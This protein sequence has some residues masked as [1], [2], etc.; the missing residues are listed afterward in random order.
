MQLELH[1]Q[2]RSC[3]AMA[4]VALAGSELDSE[5]GRNGQTPKWAEMGGPLTQMLHCTQLLHPGNSD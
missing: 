3:A 1:F 5:L 2:S 4:R